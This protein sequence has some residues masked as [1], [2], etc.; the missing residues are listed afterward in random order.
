MQKKRS[1]HGTWQR[2]WRCWRSTFCRVSRC[3]T[4]SG[5]AP[6]HFQLVR[7][8]TALFLEKLLRYRQMGFGCNR[9][10][11]A[12]VLLDSVADAFSSWNASRETLQG[13]AKVVKGVR[14]ASNVYD[15]TIFRGFDA[16][17]HFQV[18]MWLHPRPNLRTPS[19]IIPNNLLIFFKFCLGRF[20]VRGRSWRAKN[21]SLP[22]WELV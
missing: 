5:N 4:P 11:D 8:W 14:S 15:T 18:E 21:K 12:G 13:R 20:F 19:T 22:K 17:C 3:A 7:R 1:N 16:V 10:K 9:R 2:C 6:T